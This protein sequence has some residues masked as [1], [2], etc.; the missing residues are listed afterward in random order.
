MAENQQRSTHAT[1]HVAGG[2]NQPAPPTHVVID[3][4]LPPSNSQPPTADHSGEPEEKPLPRFGRPEWVIVYVTV[5]YCL[6]TL[7]MWRTIKRQVAIMDQQAK[8][9]RTS[10]ATAALTTEETLTA[11]QRQADSMETQAGHMES[12]VRTL[13]ESVAET[14]RSVNVA[15]EQLDMAKNKERARL[16]I[17]IEKFDYNP[18]TKHLF[19]QKIHWRVRLHGPTEAFILTGRMIGCIGEPKREIL[20]NHGRQMEIRSV[21][22]PSDRI[23][24]GE[25][26]ISPLSATGEDVG[27]F[28]LASIKERKGIL[29][30]MGAIVFKDVFGDA[31]L[32]RFKR[33]WAY[34][35][36]GSD[37]V[38]RECW[39]GEWVLEDESENEE[40]AVRVEPKAPNPN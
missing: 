12:Q 7:L 14:R 2:N 18:A 35:V 39:G 24:Q 32:L 4:P 19:V 33:K 21:I 10:A 22:D 15:I 26:F 23:V 5:A 28:D 40:R 16:E 36:F 27:Y 1:N 8:D 11:I 38:D 31:W 29:W 34:E 20:Q 6:I 25:C 17:E 9:A 37:E 13:G 30:C 3:P